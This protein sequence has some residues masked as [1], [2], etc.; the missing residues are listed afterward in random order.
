MQICK[1]PTAKQ[2]LVTLSIFP[3]RSVLEEPRSV[4]QSV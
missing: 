1:A 2:G 4:A 3:I